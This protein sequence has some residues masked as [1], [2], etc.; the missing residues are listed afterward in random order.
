MFTTGVHGISR[1]IFLLSFALSSVSLAA[2]PN[3]GGGN[4]GKGLRAETV[5]KS[6]G[7]RENGGGVIRCRFPSKIRKLGRRT[8][9]LAPPR[10]VKADA[11]N[12]TIRGGRLHVSG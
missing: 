11:A 2:E 9:V 12:C 3:Y 8:T 5:K 1:V 4:Q 7:V 10:I 6:D